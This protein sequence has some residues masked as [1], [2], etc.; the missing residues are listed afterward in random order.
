MQSPNPTQLDPLFVIFEQHLLN[1]Q[2]ADTDRKSFIK[3]VVQEYLTYLRKNQISIPVLL[4]PY[5]VDEISEQVNKMLVKKIYGCLTID[6]YQRGQTATKKRQVKAQYRRI[7][8][9]KAK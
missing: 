9:S 8:T 2:D 5:I 3:K 4:E 6:E 7:Q 1:F